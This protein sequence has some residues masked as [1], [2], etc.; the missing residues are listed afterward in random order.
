MIIAVTRVEDLFSFRAHR[1][2]LRQSFSHELL[3]VICKLI[4]SVHVQLNLVFCF[5]LR[6]CQTLL[7][8][9]MEALDSLQLLECAG[10]FLME[11][12]DF[13]L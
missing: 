5:T 12:R 7:Q 10:H 13:L 9:L 3:K 1:A 8:F 11:Q 6:L 2:V 4:H